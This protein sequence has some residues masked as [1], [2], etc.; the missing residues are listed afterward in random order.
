MVSKSGAGHE[1]EFHELRERKRKSLPS[2]FRR[3]TKEGFRRNN[4]GIC[5]GGDLEDG[6]L[7]RPREECRFQSRMMDRSQN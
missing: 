2:E 3:M 4:R 5:D 7:Q 1:T 6:F